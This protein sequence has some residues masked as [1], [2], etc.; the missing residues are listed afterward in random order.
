MTSSCFPLARGD[1]YSCAPMR[2]A[3]KLVIS[4]W[5]LPSRAGIRFLDAT[6]C[7]RNEPLLLPTNRSGCSWSHTLWAKS[8][9][10]CGCSGR[11]GASTV[12][13]PLKYSFRASAGMHAPDAKKPWKKR[14]LCAII[15]N[16]F[17]LIYNVFRG[18][19]NPASSGLADRAV[20]GMLVF[21]PKIGILPDKARGRRMKMGRGRRCSY[22][23]NLDMKFQR[24]SYKK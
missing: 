3:R 11:S 6:T 1:L 24:K 15:N 12:A 4:K 10:S 14:I 9:A 5:G 8:I 7:A 16:C 13:F 23:P 19:G 21:L 20:F 17:S 2:S 18:C 22:L